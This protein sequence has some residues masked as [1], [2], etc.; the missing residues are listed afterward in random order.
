MITSARSWASLVFPYFS[1]TIPHH[2]Q[3]LR[4][5][6]FLLGPFQPLVGDAWIHQNQEGIRRRHPG[7]KRFVHR[8]TGIELRASWWISHFLGCLSSFGRSSR[9]STCWS[10][11]PTVACYFP[12]IL[13]L[14]YRLWGYFVPLSP[15]FD[16]RS[17]R[18]IKLR[19]IYCTHYP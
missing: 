4:S 14:S 2:H 7:W 17:A 3:K 15:Y 18:S 10:I 12:I 1:P 8:Y 9:L 19:K 11:C 16:Q 13:R 5:V 6:G